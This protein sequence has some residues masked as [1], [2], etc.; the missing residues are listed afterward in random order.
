MFKKFLNTIWQE[1]Y[2]NN[3]KNILN[4]LEYDPGAKAIDIGCGDGQKTSEF[5]SKI[6][7]KEI[8]GID[9]VMPRLAAAQKRGVKTKVVNIEKAWALPENSF[10]V[11]ISNQVIEHILDLDHFI[12]EIKKVLKPGGY[13]VISTENL[14]SWHNIFALILGHQD[15][16]HHLISKSHVGNPMSLHY[17][18]KTVA[19]SAKDNSG[20]DD[21]AFP[22]IKIL[23]FKSLIKIFNEYG[24]KFEKGLGSGYYPLFGILSLIFCRLDPFHSHF[25]T[26]K[27]RK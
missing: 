22:H 4:L 20:V 14:A 27:V 9:G 25:I 23:T 17:K 13:A 7:A 8:L 6:G 3:T 10:D 2:A 18:Q 26:I 24:F 1:A 15:F 5:M 11:V 12:S 16:S 19:W 21:T